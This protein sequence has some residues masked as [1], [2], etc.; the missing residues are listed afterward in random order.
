MEKEKGWGRHKAEVRTWAN[1]KA[2][3]KRVETDIM[4]LIYGFIYLSTLFHLW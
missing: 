3:P 2:D 1:I 4:S